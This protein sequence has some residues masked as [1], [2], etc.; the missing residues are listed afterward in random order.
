LTRVEL[1]AYGAQGTHLSAGAGA[2]ELLG[3][4]LWKGNRPACAQVVRNCNFCH[5]FAT[6][7]RK[8]KKAPMSGA[9]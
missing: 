5:Q 4:R 8:N 6:D 1:L 3:L 9:L 2:T 7:G